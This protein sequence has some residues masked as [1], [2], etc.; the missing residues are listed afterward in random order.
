MEADA[1]RWRWT[2]DWVRGMDGGGAF[3]RELRDS[4][5]IEWTT[6]R[7]TRA[8]RVN[9]DYHG[10]AEVRTL[11]GW[12]TRT[13]T[14][15][16]PTSRKRTSRHSAPKSFIRFSA[17]SRRLPEFSQPLE[18]SGSGM[19]LSESEREGRVS[20]SAGNVE[21]LLQRTAA[22][23]TRVSTEAPAPESVQ[24]RQRGHWACSSCTAPYATVHRDLSLG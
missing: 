22:H 12:Y 14:R 2:P 9:G 18:T 10:R 6:V 7:E 23:D 11:D 16:T 21:R 13:G 17:S 20:Q 19:S 24:R 3:G 8:E 1:Q 5:R 4:R 15:R